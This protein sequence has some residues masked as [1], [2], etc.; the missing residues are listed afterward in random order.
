MSNSNFR[1]TF[2]KNHPGVH[3][4][5]STNNNDC[6]NNAINWNLIIQCS[7][8][9]TYQPCSSLSD[10]STV[11]NKRHSLTEQ[12]LYQE[13]FRILKDNVRPILSTGPNS[14]PASQSPNTVL[15]HHYIKLDSVT[16]NRIGMD[17]SHTAKCM[18]LVARTIAG[19]NMFKKISSQVDLYY[20]WLSLLNMTVTC[21]KFDLTQLQG[22]QST[23]V[24][25]NDS[26]LRFKLNYV[27]YKF[28]CK[29]SV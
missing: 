21:P 12:S 29:L 1:R 19:G 22:P 10:N 17:W 5:D 26:T 7:V 15:C 6:N 13:W 20:K 8:L 11:P 9:T 28:Y 16:R 27:I 14:K 2:C 25:L 3:T 23:Q 4:S 24:D 18:L